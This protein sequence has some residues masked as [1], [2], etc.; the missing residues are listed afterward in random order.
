MQYKQLTMVAILGLLLSITACDVFKD[1]ITNKQTENVTEKSFVKEVESDKYGKVQMLLPDFT[2]LVN[3]VGA[4]VVNVR[5]QREN[6]RPNMFGL[7]NDSD[8]FFDFFQEFQPEGKSEVTSYGSGFIISKDGYI[9]TNNHVVHD[10]SAIK[11]RLTDKR[12]FAAR[13][14]GTDPDSD[15]ALIKIEADDLPIVKIGNP[16][17]MQVGEWVAAIGTPF[18][19]ENTVTAG[20]VS[21]KKRSLSGSSYIPFIQTDVAINPGNSGG[22]LF[23]LNGEVIGINSQIYSRSGGSIGISFAVPIDVAINVAEQLKIHGTFKRGQLG[24]VVQDVTFDLAKSF[25]LEHAQGALITRIMPDGPASKANLKVGD[26]ILTVNGEEVSTFNDLPL[27]I[28]YTPPQSTVKLTVWR[29]GQT[30]ETDVVLAELGSMDNKIN[31][32][33]EII[34]QREQTFF[35]LP[36]QGLTLSPIIDLKKQLSQGGLLVMKAEKNAKRVGLAQGDIILSVGDKPVYDE[37]SM[38]LALSV[39]AN[40]NVAPI[41]V[42]RNGYEHFFPLAMKE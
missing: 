1:K 24:A 36:E 3:E 34:P 4:T 31:K 35:E 13:L 28:G 41:F 21:A 42:Q 25:Q 12:E 16:K 14:V 23:N 26:I 19:F 39:Y 29:N 38:R 9:I 30:H 7:G 8:P 33:Q 15:T 18:G 40:N 10:A 6:S 5:T 11:V 37:E 27:L 2:Q 22:P 32:P 17:N 20:I